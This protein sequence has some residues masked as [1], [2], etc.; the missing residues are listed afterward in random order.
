MRILLVDDEK[1]FVK[2]LKAIL[3]QERYNVETA[4][5]GEEALFY[6]KQ[7]SFDCVILDVMMPRLDGFSLLKQMR[8]NGDK[9]PVIFLSARA[10]IDDRV[11]G[12][13]LGGDDYLPKPFSSKELLARLKA[14]MRR[15]E[16]DPSAEMNFGDVYLDPSSYSLRKGNEKEAL[17][18][19]EYQILELFFKKPDRRYSAEEI[20]NEAWPFDAESDVSTVWVHLCNLRKK[21]QMLGSRVR[22]TSQR[23]VGYKMEEKDV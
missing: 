15:G 18:Y 17:S 22:I 14:V 12:L 11:K 21:L 3:V 5:D 6:L 1:D 9:T 13:E 8:S 16:A 4:C 23:G 7:G 20:L 2:A 19:R 10:D